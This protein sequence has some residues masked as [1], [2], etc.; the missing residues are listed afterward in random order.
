MISFQKL[1]MQE[2]LRL[3]C[4]DGVWNTSD[5]DG[6][7][8]RLLLCNGP[9][10]LRKVCRDEKT[11][12][13][14]SQRATAYPSVQ[15]L[16]NTWSRECARKMGTALADDCLD[17]D[18]DIVLAPGVN[19]KRDPLCGRNFEYFSEDPFL[20]GTLAYEYIEG[21]QAE[22]VGACLKHY[23]CNNAET[24]RYEA[25]SD[26]D[27]RTL[28]EIYLKP[29]E[30]A[31]RANPVSVM[32]AYNRVNGVYASENKKGFRILREEFGFDGAIV[33]DWSAV[34]NR[35]RAAK[36]GLDLEMPFL[37]AN[38][39]GL[40]RDYHEGKI[41]DAE[42][43]ACAR[44]VYGL[45]ARCKAMQRNKKGKYT[46]AERHKAA[47]EI[48]QEGIVLLKNEGILPLPRRASVAVCGK[49]AAPQEDTRL[50]SGG[51]SSEVSWEG[52]PFDLPQCLRDRYG[53]T[54]RYRA[55]FCEDGMISWGTGAGEAFS[56]AAASDFN[57]V[58]VGTGHK[59]E[60]EGVDRETLRL[61]KVQEE[62]IL[63]SAARNPNTIVIIF[64]GGAIDMSAWKDE[65]KAIVYAGFGGEG[66][67]EAL[68][69]IL[70]GTVNPS[71]KLSESFPSRSAFFH[72]KHKNACVSR[73]WE[74]LDVGYRY[75]VTYGVP[76]AFPFG[77]GLSYSQF[78]YED[79][80]LSAEDDVVKVAFFIKNKSDREGKEIS[81]VYVKP[82]SPYVYR[83]QY[84]LKGFSK[85]PIA[86]GERVRIQFILGKEAFSYYSTATDGWEADDGCYEILIGASSQDIRLKALLFIRSGKFCL[87]RI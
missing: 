35:T 66:M 34:R 68:A 45:I 54:V 28:R 27:E 20:T 23:C 2:K 71:G 22:G 29:F 12:Q 24:N 1:T 6:K 84:E 30:M 32:C 82:V 7:L 51:G 85:D 80:A 8:P 55:L 36:A 39:D 69:D 78:E 31:C 60:R 86:A 48:A 63:Q 58:C 9:V 57:I 75:Y 56:F 18:V 13:E 19:I 81:Q 74:G 77:H 16:A 46:A 53:L 5:L 87:E 49:Y 59:Y 40:V 37:Q 25:S 73:Y 43:D 44:R 41:A 83:P 10:G 76:V 65:V 42:V 50:I 14:Y 33:S 21:V 62:V 17:A 64:A 70:M 26:V 67:G 47:E 38:Y 4:G 79:I 3:I 72:A 11:G 61:P 15:I 52:A